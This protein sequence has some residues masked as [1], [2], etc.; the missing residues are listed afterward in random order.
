MTVG[1]VVHGK[2]IVYLIGK[3]A[4]TN[5]VNA[6]EPAED[7]DVAD[8]SVA[9]LAYKSSIPGQRKGTLKSTGF[10]GF[11]ANESVAMMQAYRGTKVPATLVMPGTAIGDN[12]VLLNGYVLNT[13]T[14][15]EIG[16]AVTQEMSVEGQDGLDWGKLLHVLGAETGTTTGASVNN[17]AS[18]ANGWAANLHV[19]AIAGADPQVTVK[20]QDSAN[21]ADWADLA[22]ASFTTATAATY[23]HL[24]GTGTV[25]QYIRAVAT[26]A[27]TTTSCTYLVAFARR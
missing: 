25:R 7:Y 6:V 21:D 11:G 3:Y 22:S 10:A 18:S 2:D 27:G 23:Q 17:A 12:L 8:T 13:T 16:S 15:A 5:W 24:T 1:T 4:A 26:F 9:G 20:I 19:T 14:P